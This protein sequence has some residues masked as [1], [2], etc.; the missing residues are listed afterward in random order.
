M[1]GDS[2]QGQQ[3]FNQDSTF[4]SPTPAPQSWP[5]QSSNWAP[6]AVDPVA[7]SDANGGFQQPSQ[8]PGPV[9]AP[10]NAAPNM[11]AQAAG[12][13]PSWVASAPDPM[14]QEP[15]VAEEVAGDWRHPT[16]QPFS[17]TESM[18]L[19]SADQAAPP[20]DGELRA[21]GTEGSPFPAETD[22][23]AG[24][25]ALLPTPPPEPAPAPAPEPTPAPA[26]A[27]A[28]ASVPVPVPVPVPAPAPA[29]GA[30]MEDVV[31]LSLPSP[32]S[33]AVDSDYFEELERFASATSGA[34]R[35]IASEAEEEDEQAARVPDPEPPVT[36][37]AAEASLPSVEPGFVRQARRQAFWRSPAIRVL[38]L[39]VALLLGTLLAAQWAVQE[40]DRLAARYPGSV[41]VL[42]WLCEPMR[43]ELGAPQ[44]IESVVIDSSNLVRRIGNFYS[45]DFV[46]KNSE[47]IALA[48]PA[49]ELSLTDGADAVI[50]RRVFL[51]E[52]LPG[53]PK[54]VPA[55]GSISISLRLSLAESGIGAMTGYRA[56]VFYP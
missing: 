20:F 46:V 1:A 11:D 39:G 15:T 32:E 25:E 14:Q 24:L 21:D 42:I 4:Q 17:E 28:P 19:A 43:C 49:L 5:A 50:A 3:P 26:P 2:G 41:P 18:P 27:P 45:F 37:E 35:A 48:M 54:V 36:E 22:A 13:V 38:L 29:P 16:G 44:R 9:A 40:R 7:P 53:M 30:G 52:E 55:S 47:P 12:L 56:L 33:D 31:G 34:A 8:A 23:S 6:N 10:V 51:Q